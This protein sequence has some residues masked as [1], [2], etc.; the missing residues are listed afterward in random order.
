MRL[1]Q[2]FAV[3]VLS[4]SVEAVVGEDAPG[5]RAVCGLSIALTV[6]RLALQISG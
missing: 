3:C 2:L 4:A 5:V 1:A 6:L